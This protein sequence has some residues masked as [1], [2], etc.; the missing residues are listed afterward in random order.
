M[1]RF[2]K[3]LLKQAEAKI[4]LFFS[5]VLSILFRENFV[6]TIN[7][8]T[9]N[10][11][12]VVKVGL[13]ILKQQKQPW[14]SML[15]F[16]D[17]HESQ[18]S[19]R[20]FK[21]FKLIKYIPRVVKARFL[22]GK[23]YTKL[24]DLT[25]CYIDDSLGKL[26]KNIDIKNTQI[27]ITGDHGYGW[28][29][30]RSEDLQSV[31]GFRTFYERVSVPFILSHIKK[32]ATGI[33]DSMSISATILD[34]LNIKSHKTFLGKSIFKRGRSFCITEAGVPGFVDVRKHDL[35]FTVTTDRFKLM[36]ILRG[37]EFIPSFLFDKINDPFE[38]INL[39]KEKNILK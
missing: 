1:I 24:H 33:Y 37:K 27:F 20:V 12:E 30:R 4:K 38:T 8:K 16:F 23:T 29:Y 13:E 7:R 34:I 31:W 22:Y 28:D 3:K 17:L 18:A 39:V 19:S 26:F 5:R 9:I 10:A 11:E 21:L 36:T 2:I 32:T 35:H 15:H 14:F 6:L 25:L